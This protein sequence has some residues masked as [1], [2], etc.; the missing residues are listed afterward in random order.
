MAQKVRIIAF[1]FLIAGSI[2]WSADAYPEPTAGIGVALG[3]NGT[4][5]VVTRI[6]PNTV[7]AAEKTIHVGD[8][9]VAVAQES[10]PTVEVRRLE[11]TVR[12]IRGAKGTM[13][14]L[15]IIPAGEDGGNQT[16]VSFKRGEF[17]ELSDWG[18]GILL[19]NGT[20]APN[21]EMVRLPDG[22][23]EQ[24]SDFSGKVIVL[25]FW[26][27]WCAPCQRAMAELE[28]ISASHSDWQDKVVIVAASV[29]DTADVAAKHLKQK[30]WNQTHNVLVGAESK[31]AYHV[32]G[33]PILYII[34]R[35][36][37]I[38]AQNPEN[39][40]TIVNQLLA[41][42][43]STNVPATPKLEGGH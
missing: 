39:I 43:P 11:E 3:A 22:K 41:E 37:R 14:R 34:D 42:S 1:L 6:F 21:I 13:V 17:K 28:S 35:K 30:G 8:R 29:D 7:A 40:E 31:R 18:D 2:A 32:G 15:T 16:V 24:L 23:S 5:I 38:A 33:I 25:E 27:T 19:T 9:I 36:G 20:E 4:N 26:A 12:L 10:G